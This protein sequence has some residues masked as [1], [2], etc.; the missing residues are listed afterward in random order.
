MINFI[1]I[2]K[3][4]MRRDYK[5]KPDSSVKPFLR[6][7]GGKSWLIKYLDVIVGDLKFNNY[8]ELFLGGGSI[9]FALAPEKEAYLSDINEELINTYLMIQKEPEKVIYELKNYKNEEK[10]YYMMRENETKDPILRAA[11]FIY[12]NKTSFNGIYRV[13]NSGKYN[14]P[15]GFRSTYN[16]DEQNLYDTSYRLKNVTLRC[17]DFESS[18]DTIKKDDLVLLDP[19]YTVSH[20]E[21][22]FIKYN[23][24]LFAMKDQIRLSEF[25]EKVKEKGAYYILTNAAHEK[26]IEI[27]DKEDD[28]RYLLSRTS[29]IGGKNSNRGKINE[30]VFTNIKEGNF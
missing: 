3:Y 11:R 8:H 6:W 1:E 22:G 4:K 19:P 30:F 15:Y 14:V 12:L 25:I 27:F 21:N 5:M 26:V 18:I 23:Q 2:K 7:A 10:F 24:K 17:N 28:K 20:N 9:F 29:L 13:N 16:I